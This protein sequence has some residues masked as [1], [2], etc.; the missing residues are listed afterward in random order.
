MRSRMMLVTVW[1][2][3]GGVATLPQ[4]ASGQE[5]ARVPG[6]TLPRAYYQ[7]A[8]RQPDLF[9]LQHGWIQRVERA[10]QLNMAVSDTLP[11]V[12]ILALFADS[13]EPHIPSEQLQ[14]ALFDGPSE[15]GTLSEFYEEV[16]GGR[17]GVKGQVAPWIRTSLTMEEVVAGSYGLG[18]SARTGEYLL[19]ALA[20]ADEIIDFGLYDNDGPDGVPNSGDDDHRVDAVAFQFLEVAA[21]CGGPSIWPHRS[22][23]EGW[24][25]DNAPFATDDSEPGGEPIVVSD[26][27]V[28][29][30]T[31]CDGV[32]AQK[33]TTIAHELGHVLGLPDLYDRSR[34][35]E[36]QHRHW[37]VGCWSLMAAG[38][39]GCGTDDRD[40]WLRPTH[41]GAW[42]K[43]QLG[44]LTQIEQV[45]PV[46]IQEL[47]ISPVLESE[48]VLKLMLEDGAQSDTNEYLLIEY[49]TQ[50]GFD[51]DI[52]AAGVLIYHVDPTMP[53]NQLLRH[54]PNWYKVALLEADGNGTL[55]RNFAEGGNRGE[56][57]DA[58]GA[59]GTGQLSYSTTPSSRLNSG[60][61]SPV[62]IY[63]ITVAGGAASITLS[64]TRVADATLMHAF[65]GTTATPLT[66]EEE[67][68]LDSYGNN[69][70][71]Y[72]VGDL[73]AYLRR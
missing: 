40:A 6:R 13:P 66:A 33:A 20:A 16:S 24:T 4:S 7:R 12:V 65:L 73:R 31:D 48:H 18:D 54:E 58:W 9:E 39:W 38:A 45:E 63:E 8:Q 3:L 68:Y 72:D 36:P 43:E 49:R 67:D 46:L 2:L 10:Q 23:I 5:L 69:N 59:S 11:L 62:T 1:T 14:Q 34:G 29:G 37:V 53:N 35:T 30:A 42:E 52:P 41:M 64:T 17:L 56:P 70:G 27:I 57:G 47:T 51:V 15:Y 55:Q 71:Q 19:E 25:E 21:S 22:R 26:Y 60:A 44:W 50:E 28:Q 61:A 32:E